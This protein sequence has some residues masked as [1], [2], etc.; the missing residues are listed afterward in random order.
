M[1]ERTALTFGNI[2]I[3]YGLKGQ[4]QHQ[5]CLDQITH[6][7]NESQRGFTVISGHS[8]VL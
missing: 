3:A 4:E 2:P 7:L 8:N 5:V 1:A 6:M